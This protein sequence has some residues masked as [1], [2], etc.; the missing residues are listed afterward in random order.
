MRPPNLATLASISGQGDDPNQRAFH[1]G[2]VAEGGSPTWR[3]TIPRSPVAGG[4][5]L[6]SES[7][8]GLHRNS[9][10]D[11][12]GF[13]DSQL[14]MFENAGYAD[15][16]RAIEAN[17]DLSAGDVALQLSAA[18]KADV[19]AALDG[20]IYLQPRVRMPLLLRLDSLLAEKGVE[21][22]HKVI[23]IVLTPHR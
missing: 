23:S 5:R 16:L 4:G 1:E 19:L 12:V 14:R 2:T 6:P 11:P 18:E 8:A 21:Y 7:V 9:H 22:D 10:L 3:A 15:V 17:E 13:T 20:P